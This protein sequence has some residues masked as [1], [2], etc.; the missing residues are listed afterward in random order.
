MPYL[1]SEALK[2]LKAYQY[3]AGGYTWLD[4]LHTPAW[5]YVVSKLPMWLAPNMITLSG[6]LA[7]V[8]AYLLTIWYLPNFQGEAPRW[9]YAASAFSVFF[10]VNLDCIDGKQARRTGSSSPLG[11]LFDHGCDALVVHI[12]IANVIANFSHSCGWKVVVGALS[13]MTPWV[14]AQWEEYHTGM[15][16]YSVSGLWGVLE[17]NYATAGVHVVTAVWGPAVWR[18]RPLGLPFELADG[19]L[20]GMTLA[21]AIQTAGQIWR[22]LK[23][24][25]S[26]MSK[27]ERGHKELGGGLAAWHLLFF[28]MLFLPAAMWLGAPTTAPGQCR[29]IFSSFGLTFALVSTQLIVA[30]MGKVAFEPAWWSMCLVFVGAANV[31]L[32]LFDGPAL[33][34]I[35]AATILCGYLHYVTSVVNEICQFLNIWCLWIKKS[36]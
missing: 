22:V 32:Q 11:Q 14:L 16:L 31:H 15:M 34:F 20:A 36:S 2:G 1:S 33:S 27:Q 17:A 18:L 8:M 24:D 3:K 21:G 30:H 26:K 35:I 28:L 23:Y 6:T 13:I 7:V 12:L 9:V 10:Y 19:A 4:D 29:A 5:N 25:T